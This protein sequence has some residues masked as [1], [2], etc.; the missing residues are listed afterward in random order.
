MPLQVNLHR[1]GGMGVHLTK[2]YPEPEQPPLLL[3]QPHRSK[4][5]PTL[6][7]KPPTL[8]RE[9]TYFQDGQAQFDGGEEVSAEN[10]ETPSSSP[11]PVLT[12]LR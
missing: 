6:S 10:P 2:G 12:P 11:I 8:R 5:S 4:A 9:S 7:S 3:F 1:W